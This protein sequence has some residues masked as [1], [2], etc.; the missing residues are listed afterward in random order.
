MTTLLSFISFPLARLSL[1]I[2]DFKVRC[3]ITSVQSVDTQ[4]LFANTH[5]ALSFVPGGCP[6]VNCAEASRL[7][8]SS[9]S[10]TGHKKRILWLGE[11][12]PQ[13]LWLFETDEPAKSL[14]LSAIV[15]HAEETRAHLSILHNGKSIF[16]EDVSLRD[17]E[18]TEFPLADGVKGK[19]VVAISLT[20]ESEPIGFRLWRD[21][22]GYET[23][24][25]ML[26]LGETSLDFNFILCCL[27][28]AIKA[29]TLV[30]FGIFCASFLSPAVSS[31]LAVFFFFLSN[32][33]QFI[34]QS[35]SVLPSHSHTEGLTDFQGP[36]YTAVRAIVETVCHI[37]PQL[38]LYSPET[39]LSNGFAISGVFLLSSLLSF[40]FYIPV[41]LFFATLLHKSTLR[42][43]QEA[44]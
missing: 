21:E 38:T 24:G 6:L 43:P 28:T 41:L 26:I 18:K 37:T 13:I 29:A 5:F 23:T 3:P 34:L 16:D 19:I 2:E 25:A 8:S 30:S 22:A 36:F 9:P 20:S 42:R 17:E 32:A 1:P 4:S 44:E 35:T 12:N 39:I 15:A 14:I 7:L 11:E 31:I 40:G 33:N 10:K 27:V